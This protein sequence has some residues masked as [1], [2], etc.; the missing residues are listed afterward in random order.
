MI[1]RSG[2]WSEEDAK[3]LPE[4]AFL[5]KI[6]EDLWDGLFVLVVWGLLLWLLGLVALY[7]G[8][9]FLPLGLLIAAF[10]VAPGLVGLM[11]V[12]AKSARGGFMRLGDAWHGTR[13]FYRRSVMLTLPLAVIGALI[14]IT[15]DIVRMYPE[16]QELALSL[17]LQVGIALTAVVLSIYV[18]PVLPLYDTRPRKTMLLAGVLVTRFLWQTGL[19]MILGLALLAATMLHPLVWLFIVGPWCVVAANTTYRL[20]RRILPEPE[21]AIDK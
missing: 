19:L 15:Q 20:A 8:L 7:A 1:K 6:F 12:C 2:V 14:W 17:A 16:R 9:V 10:T 4:P 21:S 3:P 13:R 18:Y 5:R 11:S